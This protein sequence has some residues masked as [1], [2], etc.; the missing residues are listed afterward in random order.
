V[1]SEANLGSPVYS[2]PIVAN[3]ALYITSNTHL[4]SFYDESKAKGPSDQPQKIELK[5]AA[6]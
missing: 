1:I 2:T 5:P 3:G 4:Y 6:K